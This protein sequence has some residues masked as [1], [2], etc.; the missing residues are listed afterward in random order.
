MLYRRRRGRGEGQGVPPSWKLSGQI[1]NISG[2][3]WKYSDKPENE[4][5]FF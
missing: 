3:I 5:L 4:D 1:W 2:C